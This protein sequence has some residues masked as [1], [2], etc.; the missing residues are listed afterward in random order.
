MGD[1]ARLGEAV[2]KSWSHARWPCA[3]FRNASSTRLA[4]VSVG[5]FCR[6]LRHIWR[7]KRNFILNSITLLAAQTDFTE[8]GELT[9]FIDDSQLNFLK[10]IMWDHYLDTRRMAGAFQL[11][12]SSDLIWSRVV[13]DWQ[14]S[15]MIDLMAWN[16]DATRMP[17]RMHSEYLRRLFLY[18][19]LFEGRYQVDGRPIVLGEIRVPIFAERDHVA[20]W[21]SVQD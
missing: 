17:S 13:H 7:E 16:A 5:P 8:A 10:D 18:N 11:L 1:H 2:T 20:P 9:L 6:S 3:S 14:R 12:H 4:I 21:H 15:P 19:D